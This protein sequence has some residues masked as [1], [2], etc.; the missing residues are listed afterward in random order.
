M[1]NRRS[2]LKTL[3]AC[4]LSPLA[5][6]S[7]AK[8]GSRKR[9]VY[10]GMKKLFVNAPLKPESDQSVYEATDL[11]TLYAWKRRIIEKATELRADP[12]DCLLSP[13]ELFRAEMH[14]YI[15]LGLVLPVSLKYD[16]V[17]GIYLYENNASPEYMSQQL[18][19]FHKQFAPLVAAIQKHKG[20]E[21]TGST[22]GTFEYDDLVDYVRYVL[23]LDEVRSV[24][25]CYQVFD[26]EN[27]STRERYRQIL[28]YAANNYLTIV[29]RSLLVQFHS[30]KGQQNWIALTW[31]NHDILPHSALL[32]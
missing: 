11:S 1:K 3:G 23:Q 25:V 7:S 9:P 20:C 18:S 4:L 5:F 26:L 17:Y 27:E 13:F 19:A 22:I 6:L 12:S 15:D 10:R 2:L 16:S 21:V 30:T 8:A 29:D 24:R 32:V 31:I 28:D 14:L